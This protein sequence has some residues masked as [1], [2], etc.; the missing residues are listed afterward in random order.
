MELRWWTNEFKAR[1]YLGEGVDWCLF[2]GHNAF[3]YIFED[4]TH[5]EIR[6]D[7]FDYWWYELSDYPDSESG[8]EDLARIVEEVWL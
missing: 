8:M 2:D 7:D 1:S 6:L 5:P 3:A 4:G